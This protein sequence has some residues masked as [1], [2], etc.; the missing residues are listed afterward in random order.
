MFFGLRFHAWG[1]IATCRTQLSECTSPGRIPKNL[2]PIIS[3][4]NRGPK[5][6]RPDFLGDRQ[7]GTGRQHGPTAVRGESGTNVLG[8]SLQIDCA[9]AVSVLP[10]VLVTMVPVSAGRHSIQGYLVIRLEGRI[11]AKPG[12]FALNN[13]IEILQQFIDTILVGRSDVAL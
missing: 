7:H 10:V 4:K 9:A 11:L 5:I 3:K 13:R 8:C 1:V 12:E 2:L 6:A